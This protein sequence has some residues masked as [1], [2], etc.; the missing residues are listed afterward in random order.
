MKKVNFRSIYF[1]VGLLSLTVWFTAFGAAF[2]VTDAQQQQSTQ[3]SN[4]QQRPREANAQQTPPTNKPSP[5]NPPATTATPPEV[6]E[7]NETIIV[8][9]DIVNLSVRVVDRNGRI[10]SDV[11]PK[12]FKVFE[13]N[14]EQKIEF[15]SKEDVPINYGLVVDNSGS[16]RPQLLKVIES[17]KI[18]IDAN[19]P[20]DATFIIRFISSDK[21]EVLQ[22]FTKSKD[23]L[24]E[25]L[26]D[27]MFIEPG[28]TAIRDAVMLAAEKAS[29]Y[30]KGKRLEEKTRRALILVTDGE[31]RDSYFKD[32]ELFR[33]L[34]EADVQIYPIGFVNDLSKDEGFIK[35]SPRDKAIKFLERL[36]QETGG[37][38]YFPTSLEELPEIARA[39]N[40]ELRTQFVIA[41]TPTNTARDGSFRPIKV[42]IADDPKRGK[43]IP[44]TKPGYTRPKS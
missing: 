29:D 30:E 39:I 44:V 19:K 40:N 15:V 6:E 43:R 24:N 23:E 37:K 36:A 5:N 35:K 25:A 33:V 17:G 27:K 22:D 11:N 18:L 13:N 10:V 31:D 7:D 4:G 16:L 8:E 12:E 34:R 42:T 28:Q 1:F 38:A 41:Y 21:I 3:N 26:E 20:E 2:F 32:E 9:S 14:A